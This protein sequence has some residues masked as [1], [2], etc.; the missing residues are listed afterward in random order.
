MAIIILSGCNSDL[1]T[2]ANNYAPEAF[3]ALIEKAGHD[4]EVQGTKWICYDIFRDYVGWLGCYYFVR[5]KYDEFYLQRYAEI[6]VYEDEPPG[7]FYTT[8]DVYATQYEL[9]EEYNEA[10]EMFRSD[11]EVGS[12]APYSL[13]FEAGTMGKKELNHAMRSVQ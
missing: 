3:A 4:I 9:D 5:F 7:V 1:R 8:V 11:E 6:G 13:T 2:Q 10:L 12:E